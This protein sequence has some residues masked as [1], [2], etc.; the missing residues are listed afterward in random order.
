MPLERNKQPSRTGTRYSATAVAVAVAELEFGDGIGN[1]GRHSLLRGLHCEGEAT[2][3]AWR[4]RP[5]ICGAFI[6]RLCLVVQPSQQDPDPDEESVQLKASRRFGSKK[7]RYLS[8]GKCLFAVSITSYTLAVPPLRE[9]SKRRSL[10]KVL[11][12]GELEVV[13]DPPN[14][15][16]SSDK[17]EDRFWNRFFEVKLYPN[18]RLIIES[19]G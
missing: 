3:R 18:H 4:T 2:R 10:S 5:T 14:R 12:G 8:S 15:G 1:C 17:S 16:E 7:K 13:V 9:E 19:S 6:R 11:G